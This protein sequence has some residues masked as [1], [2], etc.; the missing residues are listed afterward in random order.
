[1]MSKNNCQS[2]RITFNLSNISIDNNF[3]NLN[4]ISTLSNNNSLN[5]INKSPISN[6][7][8]LFFLLSNNNLS[9]F[10]INNL[11]SIN[12]NLFNS[13]IRSNL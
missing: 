6:N 2:N 7:N 4:N 8:Y 10:V 3:N 9:G 13:Q 12:N 5:N 11:P 1:M